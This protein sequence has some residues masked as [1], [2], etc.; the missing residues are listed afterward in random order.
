[1]EI[2]VVIDEIG[3]RI[4]SVSAATWSV[5]LQLF[6][7]DGELPFDLFILTCA[8]QQRKSSALYYFQHVAEEEFF[9]TVL[10]FEKKD[11]LAE[12]QIKSWLL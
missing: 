3:E 4:L 8:S 1:M 9:R 6:R 2:E 5:H 11:V 12:Q 7:I 10:E